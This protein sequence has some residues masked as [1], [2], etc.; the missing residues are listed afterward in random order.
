MN[1]TETEL[2]EVKLIEPNVFGDQRGFFM[3]V[4]HRE[5]FQSQ[6]IALDFVQD[7]HSLSS[8]IDT[9]RC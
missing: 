2:P 8:Q 5:K 4:Y 7:N 6:G 1:I 3:E 9:V